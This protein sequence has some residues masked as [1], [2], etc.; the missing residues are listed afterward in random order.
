MIDTPKGLAE[1]CPMGE[2]TENQ[3]KK[4][5]VSPKPGILKRI[6]HRHNFNMAAGLGNERANKLFKGL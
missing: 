6:F 5:S 3:A 2:A 1:D 4:Q